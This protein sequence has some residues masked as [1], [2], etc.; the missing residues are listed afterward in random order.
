MFELEINS[1]PEMPTVR[2]EYVS[3]DNLHMYYVCSFEC[4]KK[5]GRLNF[6]Q[7]LVDCKMVLV[8]V[9]VHSKDHMKTRRAQKISR[10]S[11]G[12]PFSTM[13]REVF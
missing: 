4:R 1:Q 13:S 9:I 12:S 2:Y 6:I 11:L 8:V 3:L 10:Q 5:M 7:T